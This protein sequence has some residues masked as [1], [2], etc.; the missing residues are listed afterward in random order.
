MRRCCEPPCDGSGAPK[1]ERDA[2]RTETGKTAVR[3]EPTGCAASVGAMVSRDGLR[4]EQRF[5]ALCGVLSG[6]A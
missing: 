3:L 2:V 4:R 6:E 5:S 1:P